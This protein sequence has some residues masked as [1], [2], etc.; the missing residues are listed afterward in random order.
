MLF[1]HNYFKIDQKLLMRLYLTFLLLIN[2]F[3]IMYNLFDSI[4]IL[5][6]LH[7]SIK[8][9]ITSPLK[10]ADYNKIEASYLENL[11]LQNIFIPLFFVDL[12][13]ALNPITKLKIDRL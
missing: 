6:D 2:I 8:L 9:C 1:L 13:T 10:Q 4:L 5:H 12:S 3:S 11:R 7:I